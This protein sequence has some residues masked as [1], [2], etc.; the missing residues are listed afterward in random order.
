MFTVRGLS[1][2]YVRGFISLGLI[3]LLVI[4][5][6]AFAGAG[7]WVN[8]HVPATLNQAPVEVTSTTSAFPS[9]SFVGTWQSVD[10]Q[11]Q[12]NGYETDYYADGTFIGKHYGIIGVFDRGAGG[13]VYEASRHATSTGTWNVITDVVSE[14]AK[15]KARGAKTP[16]LPVITYFEPGKTPL[17]EVTGDTGWYYYT[18]FSDNCRTLTM[19]YANSGE[20]GQL[21]PYVYHKIP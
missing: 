19:T 12:P 15:E 11:N 6:A 13:Y 17:K 21:L 10:E 20:E 14:V 1:R 9:C 4:G 16:G 3:L 8:K 2:T 5:L 7:W 18:A